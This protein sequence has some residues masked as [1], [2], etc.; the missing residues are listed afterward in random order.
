LTPKRLLRSRDVLHSHPCSRRFPMGLLP[1]ATTTASHAPE[2]TG[3]TH[4]FIACW[5]ATNAGSSGILER[6]STEPA[7]P[8]FLEQE[9]LGGA[10]SCC[11]DGHD[12]W[13]RAYEYQ[14]GRIRMSGHG[15]PQVPSAQST[16]SAPVG[17]AWEGISV[18]YRFLP[19]S[20]AKSSVMRPTFRCAAAIIRFPCH[21]KQ[22]SCIQIFAPNVK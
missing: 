21:S 8:L 15:W 3:S 18:S 13:Q 12:R 10:L 22:A 2:A 20:A 5:A 19:S 16:A 11:R 6:G 17:S 9:I 1:R 7:E 14:K 4:V